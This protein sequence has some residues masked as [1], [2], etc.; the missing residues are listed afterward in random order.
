MSDSPVPRADRFDAH[1][2]EPYQ[3]DGRGIPSRKVRCRFAQGSD[4]GPGFTDEMSCLL[5]TRLRGAILIIL[6][7]FVLH[8][9]RNLL[10]QGS[11]LDHRTLRLFI[12]GCE[13]VV[14]AIV[15]G[16]LWSRWTL[17]MR[18]LRI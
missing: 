16:L 14:L 2:T 5:R 18:T 8:L 4:S 3:V 1:L 11:V 7:G 10:L 17:S 6:V 13:I 15:S 9:V 12:S